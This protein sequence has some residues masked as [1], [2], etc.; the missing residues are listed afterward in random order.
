MLAHVSYFR[1]LNSIRTYL[2]LALLILSAL[3]MSAQVIV[4]EYQSKNQRDVEDEDY[5]TSDWIELYNSGSE[6]VDV[7]GYMLSD[8]TET[9]P[10]WT[11]P[12]EVELEAGGHLLIFA[13]GKNR[14]FPNLHTSFSLSSEGEPVL[15]Y[16]RD[17]QFLDMLE[18]SPLEPH[19]SF[20][21]LTDGSAE[22]AILYEATPGATN[23]LAQPLNEPFVQPA[24]GFYADAID[25]SMNR[26]LVSSVIRYS[27][28]G[29][30]PG[31]TH[32]VWEEGMNINVASLK[33]QANRL[34]LIPTTPLEGTS[35][36]PTFIYKPPTKEVEKCHIIR[37]RSFENGV[38][39]S[40]VFSASYFIGEELQERHEL[41]VLSIVMNEDELF[42][43][44][45]G[46]YVP[47][48]VFAQ[49][50]WTEWLAPGN[51][52][53][54]WERAANM[55]FF[56]GDEV[57]SQYGGIEMYGFSSR[58]F[59]QKS[60]R[61]VARERYGKKRI[62][63]CFF[64]E[65]DIC[66]FKSLLIRNSG[67]DFT[68][69]HIRDMVMQ[70]IL[71]PMNVDLQERRPTVLYLN[72]EY[73]GIVNIRTQYDTGYFESKYGLEED[74]YDLLRSN[75]EIVR[76]DNSE[77]ESMLTFLESS[78]LSIQE[79]YD[80]IA[81]QVDIENYIDYQIGEIFTGNYDWPGNNIK[82]FKPKTEEGKWR[83]LVFDLD[84]GFGYFKKEH[85]A[86]FDAMFH[87]ADPIGNPWPNPEW[88]TFLFRKLLENQSFRYAF[89]DRFSFHL[90]HTF[91]IER[92]NRIID[93]YQR[94]YE[95]EMNRHIARWNWPADKRRWDFE[96]G[97]LRGFAA[98][99]SCWLVKY[100]EQYFELN[101]F[102]FD[103]EELLG[104]EKF[105]VLYNPVSE[106]IEFLY[107]SDK[108]VQLNVRLVNMQGQLIS[109]RETHATEGA[110]WHYWQIP[111]ITTGQYILQISDSESSY[112]QTMFVQ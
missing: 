50:N 72:G 49:S 68:D 46:M 65:K 47:G 88:S 70:E 28:D 110:S 22:S 52:N 18:A 86:D 98:G 51:Y 44:E 48:K 71:E 78:D 5:E 66:N 87:A 64:P 100:L 57:F 62:D 104:E 37:Y 108:S 92:L 83:W 1:T 7:G 6:S 21:R 19:R 111:S 90:R 106:E 35:S 59:P 56:D 73:W 74:D 63:H 43:Y 34:S 96:V 26:G 107:S 94:I 9:G 24:A 27:T 61:F 105:V 103:C 95:P 8:N 82:Y 15:L 42:D 16:D 54:E 109:I 40:D 84:M 79:N 85:A 30:E 81:A 11:I 2:L 29:S 33:G 12:G 69:T 36:L 75:A 89:L 99:R 58:I 97:Y 80:Q 53:I 10:K 76:G 32:P 39:N 93:K 91:T 20:G 112:S 13:S 45:I 25:L 23:E 101:D 102:N 38:A 41:P 17:G 77:Y 3:P 67:N 60:F 14:A 31:P 4:N 55:E